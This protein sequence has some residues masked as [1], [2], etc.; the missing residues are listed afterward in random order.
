L[1]IQVIESP[2]FKYKK[3]EIMKFVITGA[4]GHTSKPIVLSLLQ[5]DLPQEIAKNFAGMGSAFRTGKL[6]EEYWEQHPDSFGK[7]E[8]EDFAKSFATAYNAN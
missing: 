5:A 7:T 8:L 3:I 6:M 1:Y 2:L 4:A